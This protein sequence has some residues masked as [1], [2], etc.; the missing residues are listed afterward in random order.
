MLAPQQPQPYAQMGA[1]PEYA[2]LP[3]TQAP[4]AAPQMNVTVSE[5]E[6]W[7]A[8]REAGGGRVTWPARSPWRAGSGREAAYGYKGQPTYDEAKELAIQAK[9][10]QMAEAERQRLE[11]EEMMRQTAFVPPAYV[12]A[13]DI[14]G[15]FPTWQEQRATGADVAGPGGYAAPVEPGFYSFTG[16]DYD[17]LE[18]LLSERGMEQVRRELGPRGMLTSSAYPRAAAEVGS[19]AVMGRMQLQASEQARR[20]DWEKEQRLRRFQEEEQRLRG[21]LSSRA[22]AE[23]EASARRS[24]LWNTAL[25]QHQDYWTRIQTLLQGISLPYQA[26]PWQTP[27]FASPLM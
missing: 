4:T 23:Q 17:A 13:E 16:G 9:Q 14:L 12:G 21:G 24:W 22:Q 8:L 20:T 1:P 26:V 11:Q 18:N 7:A 25:M 2:N 3:P 10:Q 6:I 19:Q 15:G 5:S 27:Q